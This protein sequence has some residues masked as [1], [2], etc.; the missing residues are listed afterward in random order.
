LVDPV[1]SPSQGG[2]TLVDNVG[3]MTNKGIEL[4]VNVNPIRTKNFNW[5]VYGVFNN[6]KNVITKLGSP[7]IQLATVSGAPAYLI[8]GQPTTVFFTTFYAAA[9][10][11][12][13]LL[14]KFGLPQT[15]KGIV[16][17]Y[18]EGDAILP[19]AYVV[20]GSQYV[21]QRSAD[22]Q[23]TPLSTKVTVNG[24]TYVVSELRKVTGNPNPDFTLTFGT[25]LKYKGFTFGFML[26][27]VYGNEVFNADKRTRQ[28]V[29]IGDLAEQEYT[30]AVKRGTIN[31]IYPIEEWRLDDGSFTKIRE[32]SLAYNFGKL[33]PGLSDLT[34]SAVGRNLYS[35]D[36]YNGYDPE[37]N[38]GG[39]SDRLRGIDF[40]NIPIPRSFQFGVRASF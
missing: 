4:S 27:G 6:N 16:V 9:A 31:A 26:D 10:D 5:D 32:A 39:T 12:S 15:E 30:G 18:K 36:K 40:G 19:G 2:T 14:N 22:G 24:K 34:I 17:P 28:G 7:F 35:F 1:V 21:P 37:T 23:P 3:E 38:A 20:A 8:E 11:G 13:H 29:G 25:N 33:I